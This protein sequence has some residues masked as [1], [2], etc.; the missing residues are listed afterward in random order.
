M[1]SVVRWIA[2]CTILFLIVPTLS[3][4]A[5]APAATPAPVGPADSLPDPRYNTNFTQ[6]DRLVADQQRDKAYDEYLRIKNDAEA[7]NPGLAADALLR[8]ALL[9]YNGLKNPDT[10]S[11]AGVSPEAQEAR[12]DKQTDLARKAH[13]IFKQFRDDPKLAGTQVATYILE[14]HWVNSETDRPTDLKTALESLI[15]N[16]NS[17]QL[18]YQVIDKLVRITGANSNFSYWFA[19]VIIAVVVKAITFPLTLRTYKSQREMQ[20]VQPL[21]KELQE[22]YKNNKQELNEKMMAFYKEHKINPFASCVPMI[23]Q[24]PFMYYVYYAIRLYEYHFSHGKFLWIGSPLSH[25]YSSFVATDLAKFD[26]PLLVLYAL[27]NYLTMKLNPPADP[28]QA[29]TQKTTSVMMTFMLFY[30]FM[31]YQWSAAFIFY[32]LILNFI[33]AFQQYNYIY[34]PNRLKAAAGTTEIITGTDRS[35]GGTLA[36]ARP[37]TPIPGGT[38]SRPRPK[39]RKRK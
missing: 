4:R 3:A 37:L 25:Q 28:T 17:R 15:D 26:V 10:G 33:S 5:Q 20:R 39:P 14:P 12:R 1:K 18:S 27:S 29:Q 32:W 38:A 31:K 11:T 34:K 36:D 30:M 6:A 22:K 2:I 9:G 21:M 13:D 24:L 19:L 7:T 8:A 23:V 16:R 35:S